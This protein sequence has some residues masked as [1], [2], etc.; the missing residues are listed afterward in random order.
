[1][2]QVL[3]SLTN[4]VLILS[5]GRWLGPGQVGVVAIGF[6]AY[7]LTLVL[8]RSLV[9]EPLVVKAA[10]LDDRAWRDLVA[11]AAVTTGM[12]GLAG[13]ALLGVAGLA[14]GGPVGRGLLLFSPWI[15]PAL[16][17]DFWRFI[18]FREDRGGAAAA[19]DAAWVAVSL[20]ALPMALALRSSWGF[21]AAWGLGATGGA[22]LG[23][24]QVRIRP[25]RPADAWRWW[26]GSAWPL[27]A[28]LGL[29]RVIFAL[30]TQGAIL[31]LALVLT[32]TELGGLRAAQSIFAPV[33]LI[34]PAI[35]LPGLPALA[36]ALTED[37][38]SARRIAMR[39]SLFASALA[40][41]YM[42]LAGL[43]GGAA[44]RWLFGPSFSPF[45]KLVIPLALDQ[46]LLSAGMGA[47]L[48]LKAARRTREPVVSHTLGT[49]AALGFGCWFGAL[50]GAVGASWGL[51]VGSLVATSAVL[52][53]AARLSPAGIPGSPPRV[54]PA[55]PPGVA[56]KARPRPAAPKVLFIMG[57][58]RSGSTILDNMLGQLPG[59]FSVG[60]LHQFWGRGLQE[61]RRCGCGAALRSRSGTARGPPGSR[62]DPAVEGRLAPDP[63]HL[64][65]P[66]RRGQ[67]VC[68]H[69]TGELRG[70][71]R[72]DA[73]GDLHRDRRPRHRGLVQ[74]ATRCRR[75]A[76]PARGDP[77]PRPRGARPSRR[78]LLLAAAQAQRGHRRPSIRDGPARREH[79]HAPLG[80][81]E[82]R[83]R[84]GP[85]PCPGRSKHAAAI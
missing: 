1:M 68:G 64:G 37:L 53:V 47:F 14:V 43:L 54:E 25:R 71:D 77:V 20:A 16:L 55:R 78:G 56:A 80:P 5:V 7:L 48:L 60:E 12:A 15:V 11:S 42:T 8:Q 29:D 82:L 35:G 24:W 57:W 83:G 63:L 67:A 17:Q 85:S 79:E 76:A 2:D 41:G 46:T 9:S 66:P 13:S 72:E 51:A 65:P 22:L 58:G 84:G 32:T 61:R 33:T 34:G 38:A 49:V 75:H 10:R 30:G 50:A 45:S 31:V 21:V 73:R 19:N 27:G 59:F 3:S 74:A 69:R 4:F 26:R 44:L 62:G 18:L 28:W 36:R 40:V 39:L 23:L 52:V 70:S 81:V 6:S